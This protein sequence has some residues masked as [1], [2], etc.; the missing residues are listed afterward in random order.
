MTDEQAHHGVEPPRLAPRPLLVPPVESGAEELFGRPA[1]VNGSFE[2]SRNGAA[3]AAIARAESSPPPHHALASA[4]GRPSGAQDLQ[5]PPGGLA[6]PAEP[7]PFWSG[8]STRDPWRD[9]D[10]SVQLGPPASA[11]TDAP[12]G[13]PPEGALLSAREVLFGKRVRPTALAILGVIAL[14]IGAL[15][16]VV[17]KLASDASSALLQP[18]AT[19]AQVDPGKERPPGSIAG[20]AARVLPAVVSIDVKVGDQGAAGSG[21]VIDKD[22]HIL[23]NNHVVGGAADVPGSTITAKFQDGTQVPAQLVGRDAKTDLAV[24]RVN[25]PNVTVARIGTSA[26]LAVGDSVIAIGSPLGLAGTVT[27]GIV[28]ALHRPV[29]PNAEGSDTDA[30]IDAVQTDAAIN[31]GNS[32]GPLV[33]S[34]GAVIGLDTAISTSG[35]DSG[36]I[37][38]GFAIPIDTARLVAQEL[39]RVG[40]VKH[41]DI[42]LD[43]STATNGRTDGAEV[44][45]V[46][47]GSAA[48]A[49]GIL[50]RDVVVKVGDR[51]IGSANELQVAVEEHKIGEQV[52]VQLYRQGRL[53]TV[54]V[55]LHSD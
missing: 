40:S 23:T 27:H 29:R 1:G 37:G 35:Q 17:G 9:P 52:P 42:G 44:Q 47:P 32:G 30:V 15:G 12:A 41:P 11:E 8:G 50:E 31:P 22:G 39:I 38:L 3:S 51:T 2:A 36:S 33:D 21:V 46:H 48:A 45:N 25:V 34:S 14:L 13:P 20:I 28:S 54:T 4:F 53:L 55:T 10:A 26:N 5:R 24:I 16:G 19:I 6:G 7:D 43:A 49:A 18:G